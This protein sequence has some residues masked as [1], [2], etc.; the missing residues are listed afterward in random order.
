MS[1]L[2]LEAL[3]DIGQRQT[4][5]LIVLNDNEM[6]ISPT[7]GA[8]WKY[9]RR[10]SCRRP[11]SRAG[12][13]TTGPIERLPV[14]GAPRSS[15]RSGCAVGGQLRPARA[16]VRGPR[17][18]LHR[19]RP[20]PRPP[21]LLRDL[22]RALELPG[23]VIVHVRTQKG[24]GYRP[25]ETDQVGFHGAA[26]PPMTIAAD[27]L[28]HGCGAGYACRRR[29]G[30]GRDAH[31]VD[32]RR[33]RAAGCRG[34]DRARRPTTPRS[35]SPSSSSSART[36]RRIVAITAGMPTGTGLKRF[37]AEFPERFFDVGI[38]E[39]HAVTLA[40][41]LAM[42]GERPVVAIYS[43]FLQRAF[44]QTVHDVCQNDQPVLSPWTGRASSARTGPATRACSRCRPSASSRTWSS[45][46]RRTSRSCG[47][48]FGRPS[49]RTTRSRC[50]IRATPGFDLPPVEPAVIPIGRASCSARAEIAARRLRADRRAGH[51]RPQTAGRRGLVGRGHQRSLRQA[52]RPP[53]HPRRRRAASGSSS[54]SRRAS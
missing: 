12:P 17:H 18:H 19:G 1:G 43:T 13:P 29:G 39:H 28:R 2:S 48:C 21:A 8:L 52:A 16:A 44:D 24:R 37:Q 7:V 23:P 36:D 26:L 35:S 54:P 9:L 20:G 22:R 14:I 38:A 34:R 11:G 32:G 41:G 47:R 50:T 33:R 49:P 42:G 30:R 5:M 10:S 46:A 31:R 3:N 6:S 27:G 25:A 40:T 51:R 15:C 45:P 53:A 4:Q